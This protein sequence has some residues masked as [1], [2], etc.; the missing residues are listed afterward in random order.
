MLP[1]YNINNEI[2]KRK[3]KDKRRKISEI[4]L[5]DESCNYVFLNIL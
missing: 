4:K 2:K 1:D 5:R 3:K